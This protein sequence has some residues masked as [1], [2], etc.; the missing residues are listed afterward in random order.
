[1][2]ARLALLLWFAV[3]VGCTAS[4]VRVE[5]A[6][7]RSVHLELTTSVL[8]TGEPSPRSIQFLERHALRRTFREDP[9]GTLALVH[10]GL[11]PQ[12]D[13]RRLA[14]LAELSF[15]HA[16]RT[17]ERPH[18]AM[19]AVYAYALLFPGIG[20]ETLDPSD[21]RI[22]LA[23]DLYNRGL[24]EALATGDDEIVLRGGTFELPFGVLA[25]D[26]PD[27][28]LTWAGHQLRGF[29]AA[30]DLEVHGIRNRY[31]RPG[32]G[33]PLSAGVGPELGPEATPTE[34]FI[35][36]I[37]VPATVV[38]RID[39]PRR[40]LIEGHLN[41]RAE[42]HTP[43]GATAVAIDGRSVPLEFETT[44]SL[45]AALADSPFWDFE[46]RGFFSGAFRPLQRVVAGTPPIEDQTPDE[47]LLFLS[48]Y[49]R[50]RIPVVLVHG[51]ASSP[52]RWAD[53]VNELESDRVISER[54]QVWLYLYNTGNPIGYSAGLLRR[55]LEDTVAD[56]D[57]E[58]TDPALRRMVVIGHSQGGLLTKLTAIDSGDRLWRIVAK[59]PLAELD[60][61]P[62]VRETLR[63]STH[64]RPEP[65]VERVV[66]LCTPHRGSYLASLRLLW[67]SLRVGSPIWWPCRAT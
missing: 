55:A 14:A 20:Q 26:L 67:L 46:L 40:G 8:T 66:F 29:V 35:P 65:F 17:G 43:D 27:E 37:R 4:P 7:P 18:F 38:L 53:L 19:S 31:R 1:M 42:I 63:I 32:I 12:G 33:A 36:G 56:L 45:A 13:H 22:R 64:F 54:Y 61:D 57:P 9:A 11:A 28:E 62:D 51:T 3:S 48:P 44:S 10:R 6:D 34:R 59:V 47:G 30:A 15:Y 52:G 58:G 5:R 16:T 23:Y 41:A 21:P 2:A 24:T 60:L 49:R 25:V 50:E 39:D